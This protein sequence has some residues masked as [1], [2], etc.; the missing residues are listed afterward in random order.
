M[1][2]FFATVIILISVTTYAQNLN[3]AVIVVN[4]GTV[5]TMD[6]KSKPKETEGS[7]YYNDDWYTGTIKLF[8]G[9]EIQAYPLKYD[10]KMNQID[11]KVNESVKVISIG[12]IKEITWLKPDG[13]PEVL[14]NISL[15]NKIE[16]YGF[17]SRST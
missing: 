13:K 1:K 9:E 12:A 7:F 14:R 6:I 16:G 3:D 10:M 17:L 5:Q 15:F 11:I 8:S 2:S 4:G